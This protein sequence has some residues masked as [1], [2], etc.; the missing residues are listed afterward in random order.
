MKQTLLLLSLIL[1]NI[2]TSR[3][4]IDSTAIPAMTHFGRGYATGITVADELLTDKHLKGVP[5]QN[6]LPIESFRNGFHSIASNITAES[7]DSLIAIIQKPT[8]GYKVFAHSV[9][10]LVRVVTKADSINTDGVQRGIHDYFERALTMNI[11]YA[12]S[13]F[14]GRDISDDM[15]LLYPDYKEDSIKNTE[16][17]KSEIIKEPQIDSIPASVYC[18][19]AANRLFMYPKTLIKTKKEGR[20]TVTFVIEKDV[21]ISKLYISSSSGNKHINQEA[22]HVVALLPRF[23]PGTAN[24]KPHRVS[25]TLPF[26]LQLQ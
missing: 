19:R 2:G 10:A 17:E 12:G 8:T 9:G 22:L 13:V 3:A 16:T 18:L 24:G 21:Y 14:Y 6:L 20:V 25:Y 4:Q 15:G 7:S 5:I 23:E 26:I 11:E 1:L